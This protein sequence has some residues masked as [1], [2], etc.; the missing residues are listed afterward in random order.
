MGGKSGKQRCEWMLLSGG[1]GCGTI[2]AAASPNPVGGNLI[3]ILQEHGEAVGVGA[4]PD[5]SYCH[6]IVHSFY[7]LISFPT[8]NKAIL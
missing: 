4:V 2:E 7:S 1:Q 8:K 6:W 5:G 3:I